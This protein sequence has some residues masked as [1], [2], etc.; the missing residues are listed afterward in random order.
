NA[1]RCFRRVLRRRI[2]AFARPEQPLALFLDDLNSL[3]AATRAPLRYLLHRSA[4]S[5]LLVTGACRDNH[6]TPARPPLR[7][8]AAIRGTARVQ[9]IKLAPLTTN[10][11]GNLV[12]DSVRCDAEQAD[13]LAGL[14][15]AKTDGNPFF[16]IQ[17][18]HVLADEGLLAFDH[19]RASWSWDLGGIHAK[20]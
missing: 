20:R 3:D 18:L 8:R 10:D 9:D 14:V 2:R 11:L 7:K 6:A 4:L 16:V 12:A 1:P 17:F 15:H 5:N 13:P 19:E